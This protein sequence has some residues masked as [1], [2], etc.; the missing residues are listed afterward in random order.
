MSL[1][2]C[3]RP[4]RKLFPFAIRSVTSAE[5]NNPP[6]SECLS[7]IVIVTTN[8]LFSDAYVFQ[9]VTGLSRIVAIHYRQWRKLFILL[10]WCILV[11]ENK[12]QDVRSKSRSPTADAYI[13]QKLIKINQYFCF[14]IYFSHFC[15]WRPSYSPTVGRVRMVSWYYLSSDE[16][17]CDLCFHAIEHENRKYMNCANQQLGN[18]RPAKLTVIFRICLQNAEIKFVCKYDLDNFSLVQ[19]LQLKISGCDKTSCKTGEVRLD[20]Y[21]FLWRSWFCCARRIKSAPLIGIKILRYQ[22]KNIYLLWG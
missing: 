20:S 17:T 9:S 18:Y 1:I 5:S 15:R 3:L 22:R 10:Q 8:L 12:I 2:I 16:L 4:S 14:W 19:I 7:K 21:R 11:W 13:K 6:L